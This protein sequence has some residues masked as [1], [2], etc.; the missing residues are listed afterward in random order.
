MTSFFFG[1][2]LALAWFL[3]FM[4][5]VIVWNGISEGYHGPAWPFVLLCMALL[6]MVITGA[7]SHVR[8]VRLI[9]GQVDGSSL[10][11][12][13]RRQVEIPF[14]AGEAFSL[15]D[16]AVRELPRSES[17]ESAPD[18]L[19]LRAKVHRLRPRGFRFAGPG[20]RWKLP[21][22]GAR[23][24]F[25]P[26]LPSA[27]P[28]PAGTNQPR[29]VFLRTRPPTACWSPGARPLMRRCKPSSGSW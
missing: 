9:M 21:G 7:F 8:R 14:E 17:V 15:L 27:T 6:G 3:A 13:Q 29:S 10:S 5:A 20:D 28:S 11:S 23:K 19:Q 26:M 16:A 4:L 18:S 2:R 12:R 22:E 25:P 1:I 24:R